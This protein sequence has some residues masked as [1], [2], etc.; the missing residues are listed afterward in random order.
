MS[1]NQR[2]GEKRETIVQVELSGECFTF[3]VRW[4]SGV[5]EELL[6]LG[7]LRAGR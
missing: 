7:E 2:R 1:E 5:V 3:I 4:V 6:E